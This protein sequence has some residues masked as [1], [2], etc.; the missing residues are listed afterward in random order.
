MKKLIAMTIAILFVLGIA[1][2]GI[3][4][5]PSGPG[6]GDILGNNKYDSDPHK[7]FRFVR[8]MPKSAQ[9]A[10]AVGDMVVWDD[11]VSGDDGVSVTTT[12][13]SDD[14]KVAG[15]MATAASLPDSIGVSTPNT[16]AT[17]T[18]HPN[19][20]FLQTY[21]YATVTVGAGDTGIRSGSAMGTSETAHAAGGFL[22]ST[23]DD[24]HQGNAGFF[25]DDAS[26]SDTSVEVFLTRD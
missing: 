25:L 15:I 19:W 6:T 7:S 13:V 22:P 9:T 11:S 5:T 14:S 12:T 8:Y 21:G 26:A 2:T 16:A 20:G 1:A 18:G 23:T 3:A 4:K 24:T 17:D 10:L